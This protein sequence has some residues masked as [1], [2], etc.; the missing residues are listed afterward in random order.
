MFKEWGGGGGQLPPLPPFSY[1]TG[2]ANYAGIIL[3]IIGKG[4]MPEQCR[5]NRGNFLSWFRESVP[6][7]G[8]NAYI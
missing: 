1:T 7:C 5:H 6:Q 8:T 3:G 2:H 4:I